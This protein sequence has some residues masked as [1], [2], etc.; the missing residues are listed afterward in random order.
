MKKEKKLIINKEREQE[1][2]KLES[3]MFLFN[4]YIIINNNNNKITIEQ[5]NMHIERRTSVD[6]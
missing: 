2:E 4:L 5:I 1:R 6:I 3:I